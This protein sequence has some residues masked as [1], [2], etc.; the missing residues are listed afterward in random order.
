MLIFALFVGFCRVSA[1][2]SW[3]FVEFQ[4]FCAL[5]YVI[6]ICLHIFQYIYV[7]CLKRTSMAK[8]WC[9]IGKLWNFVKIVNA[10]LSFICWVISSLIVIEMYCVLLPL[11]R[12]FYMFL[13]FFEH[14]FEQ[15]SSIFYFVSVVLPLKCVY[16]IFCLVPLNFF[17]EIQRVLRA[18]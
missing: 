7:F 4:L 3:S 8:V 2:L 16:S 17:C 12:L 18:F 1:E 6:L 13:H 11:F 15:F 9:G 14:F 5:C 10:K